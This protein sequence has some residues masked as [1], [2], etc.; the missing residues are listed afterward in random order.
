[1]FDHKAIRSEFALCKEHF[2]FPSIIF[3]VSSIDGK[4]SFQRDGTADVDHC[5][6]KF[7]LFYFHG[8]HEKTT[9]HGGVP[10]GVKIDRFPIRL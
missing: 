10:C 1:M 9:D 2:L 7:T 4:M 3:Q 6:N 8:P 5:S